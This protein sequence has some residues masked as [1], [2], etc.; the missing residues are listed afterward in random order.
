[1]Y[2]TL[3][4]HFSKGIIKITKSVAGERGGHGVLLMSCGHCTKY[5]CQ[6]HKFFFYLISYSF[7]FLQR[8]KNL[9]KIETM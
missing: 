1:M 7:I 4:Q 8:K 5:L 6:G 2:S 3:A 9:K